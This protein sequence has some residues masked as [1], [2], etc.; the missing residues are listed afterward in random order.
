MARA[1]QHCFALPRRDDPHAA[2]DKGAHEDLADFRIHLVQA[3]SEISEIFMRAFILR[4][5][6]IVASGQS[7]AMLLGSRHSPGTL[8]LQ[9]FL[10]RNS[11]PYVS[12]DID[13][14]SGV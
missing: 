10:T 7:E 2:Q 12:V 9:E 8:R 13:T 3:D 5:M 6:G 11:Y 4:R 1:E 14:D